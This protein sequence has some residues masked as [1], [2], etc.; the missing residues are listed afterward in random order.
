M[1]PSYVLLGQALLINAHA[2]QA[3]PRL[4]YA[5]ILSDRGVGGC[6]TSSGTNGDGGGG[7]IRAAR[8][9]KEHRLNGTHDAHVL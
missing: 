1:K 9:Q 8:T 5:L 4:Q 3:H 6:G 7:R 2:C